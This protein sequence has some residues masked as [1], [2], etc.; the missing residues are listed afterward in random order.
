MRS[1]LLTVNRLPAATNRSE[2]VA[3][4]LGAQIRAGT[5]PPGFQLP[6][7]NELGQQ[8][9]VSRTVVREA[10]ARLK[11]DGVIETRQGARAF[12]AE[13]S[14]ASSLRLDPDI[15]QSV[16]SVLQIVEL[17]KGIE[18][19]AAA[20]AAERRGEAELSAIRAA[21]KRVAEDVRAGGDGVEADI[22]FH[23]AIS[24]ATHNP[25]FT[26]TLDYLQRFLHDAV[27]L[28]RANEARRA[29]FMREV[30]AEHE[31]IVEAIAKG[32]SAAARQAVLAHVHNAARRIEEA[33]ATFWA[34]R[35]R[36]RAQPPTRDSTA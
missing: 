3:N 6:S 32:D 27:S 8:F 35:G 5:L 29:D 31:A 11:S 20:L 30:D 33:D 12:V 15:A 26:A 23:R 36:E 21:L 7:E 10:I 24:A 18:A 14:R 1:T 9:G 22:A 28:T 19:E 2:Q 17:R 34:S 16:S 4:A 25:Y 13:P